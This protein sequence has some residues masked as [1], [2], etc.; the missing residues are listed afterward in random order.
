VRDHTALIQLFKELCVA[1]QGSACLTQSELDRCL[2]IHK[3]VDMAAGLK[4]VVETAL[5]QF[6]FQIDLVRLG[7]D[8]L[9]VDSRY[10]SIYF[11]MRLNKSDQFLA[12]TLQLIDDPFFPLQLGELRQFDGLRFIKLRVDLFD[13]LICLF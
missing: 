5:W 7:Q 3:K 9:V 4:D 13:L 10:I 11:L 1:R 8:F 2:D 6:E 12:Q